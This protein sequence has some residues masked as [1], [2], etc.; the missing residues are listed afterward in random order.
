MAT[1]L[2]TI[3]NVQA[4]IN[5][6]N[7]HKLKITSPGKGGYGI[8][9]ITINNTTY[10]YTAIKNQYLTG[11]SSG[12]LDN[13]LMNID[14]SII[15]PFT[16]TNDGDVNVS[17]RY[18]GWNCSYVWPVVLDEGVTTTVTTP[19]TESVTY[20]DYTLENASSDITF[21][22]NADASNKAEVT[23]ENGD[24]S[25]ESSINK[26]TFTSKHVG[27]DKFVLKLADNVNNGTQKVE[28]V[29]YNYN[30][31]DK[32][33]VLDYGLKTDLFADTNGILGGTTPYN[34]DKNFSVTNRSILQDDTDADGQY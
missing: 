34:Y 12:D 27:Y 19:G 16:M 21:T 15:I 18:K 10:G 30:V 22:H 2:T 11:T 25:N 24:V 7:E 1:G 33:Y 20:N 3:S 31:N 26:M 28:V 23:W 17:I 6:S 13:M 29:V 14:G 32:V 4:T 8:E 5:G 9:S